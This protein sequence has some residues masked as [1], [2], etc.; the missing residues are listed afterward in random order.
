MSLEDAKTYAETQEKKLIDR[1][2]E[3]EKKFPSPCN[4]TIERHKILIGQRAIKWRRS[5]NW[6]VLQMA[7]T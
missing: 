3:L 7:R 5:I 4:P 1:L 6:V 2:V